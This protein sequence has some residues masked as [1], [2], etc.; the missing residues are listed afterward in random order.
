VY[1]TT[2]ERESARC[3]YVSLDWV[4][5]ADHGSPIEAA[6][7]PASARA[8]RIFFV[9]AAVLVG[10]AVAAGAAA[11]PSMAGTTRVTRSGVLTGTWTGTLSGSAGGSIRRERIRIV[12]NARESAGSWKVS[13]TCHG[14]LTLDS[15]S[16]GY[17]H[18]RRRVA[19]D[20]SCLGGDIDCLKRVGLNIEDLVTPRPGGYALNGTLHRVRN[21]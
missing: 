15:V 14:S 16:G 4:K 2:P 11:T 17:H 7:E 6:M 13:P 9:V 12:V 1:G 18:Y 5:A 20:A 3:L 21:V 8:I 19:S 10:V